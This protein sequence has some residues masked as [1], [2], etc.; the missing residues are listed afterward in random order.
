MKY[1]NYMYIPSDGHTEKVK[2]K[3]KVVMDRKVEMKL[4]SLKTALV[5]KKSWRQEMKKSYGIRS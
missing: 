3:T 1:S 5:V 2:L 4:A